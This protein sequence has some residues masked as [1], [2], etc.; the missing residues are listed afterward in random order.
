ML[1][2]FNNNENTHTK[3]SP[4]CI[5]HDDMYQWSLMIVFKSFIVD[6]ILT[7]CCQSKWPLDRCPLVKKKFHRTPCWTQRIR[8]SRVK[9]NKHTENLVTMGWKI[10]KLWIFIVFHFFHKTVLCT[11]ICNDQDD[12][13]IPPPFL[14]LC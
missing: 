12:D 14:F 6:G 5:L 11:W 13:I 4:W 8:K 7:L 10:T 9:L 3:K 1:K 2:E